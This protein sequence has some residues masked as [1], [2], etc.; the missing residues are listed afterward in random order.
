MRICSARALDFVRKDGILNT[1]KVKK[2]WEVGW[3][4]AIQ[5]FKAKWSAFEINLF[6]QLGAS[7]REWRR[8]IRFAV[9]IDGLE[10]EE[11]LS[12]SVE[13]F[14]LDKAHGMEISTKKT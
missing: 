2:I 8:D 11:E 4:R 10:G 7:V 1:V 13:S 12:K 5:R 6:F 3:G 9:Y 14:S